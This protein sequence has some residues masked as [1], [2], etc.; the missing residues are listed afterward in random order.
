MMDGTCIAGKERI[1][2]PLD[3]SDVNRALDL[4]EQLEGSVGMFKIGLELIYGLFVNDIILEEDEAISHFIQKRALFAMLEGKVFLDVKLNDIPNTVEMAS[5]V[6][7]KL[8]VR[9]FN[10]HAS[11]GMKAIAAAARVK[12]KAKLLVVTILTSI[13]EEACVSIFGGVPDDKVLQFARMA[14]EAGADGII[15]SPQELKF[16]L[17]YKEFDGFLKVVPGIR[18]DWAPKNDQERIMN[19]YG[20]IIYGADYIVVG[21]PIT[22]SEDPCSAA[23]RVREEIIAAEFFC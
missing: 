18:P 4:V 1:I 21:R 6:I 16:L 10:V 9:M 19:P 14:K 15:C 23:A 11:S 17:R 5:T 7:E 22:G 12:G 8:G 13:K 20:A 3:V 2:L